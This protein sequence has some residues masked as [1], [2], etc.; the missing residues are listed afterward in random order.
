MLSSETEARLAEIFLRISQSE[1][2]VEECRYYLTKNSDFDPSVVFVRLDRLQMNSI[3][4]TEFLSLLEKHK[5]YCSSDEAYLIIRQYDTNLDGRLSFQEFLQLV[6]PSTNPSLREIALSRRGNFTTEVEYLFVRLLQSELLFH[7]S[8]EAVRREIL[9]RPDFNLLEAFRT[10]D[11]RNL[12]SI[13]RNTLFYFLKKHQNLSENDVDSI[14]RRVD[15]DGDGAISYLEFVDS[16]MPNRS[17]LPNRP[18]SPRVIAEKIQRNSS[19]LRNTS[20]FSFRK[21]SPLKT[22]HQDL[23]QSNLVEP[24]KSSPLRKTHYNEAYNLR[25]QDSRRFSPLKSSPVNKINGN[26]TF[27]DFYRPDEIFARNSIPLK[28]SLQRSY[29]YPAK[30]Y[31]MRKSSPLRNSAFIASEFSPKNNFFSELSKNSLRYTLH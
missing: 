16:V 14:L 5:I 20:Q 23:S 3:S 4:R 26:Q 15:N 24:R 2:E 18:S 19:P 17:I 22:T 6:L 28:S 1:S 30:E 25:S 9:L 7:R 31:S 13:D 27:S 12:S 29:N 10:I 21:S 8:L 11:F